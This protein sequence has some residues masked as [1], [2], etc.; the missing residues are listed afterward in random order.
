MKIKDTIKDKTL[1]YDEGL[2]KSMSPMFFT[3][4]KA[5]LQYIYEACIEV[6][7]EV[8]SHDMVYFSI[9]ELKKKRRKI[10]RKQK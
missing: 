1:K 7:W 10:C 8:S 3:P 9:D 5:V 4:A 6:T 2:W